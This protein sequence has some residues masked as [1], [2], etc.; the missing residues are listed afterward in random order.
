MHLLE[1]QKQY[2]NLVKIIKTLE[3]RLNGHDVKLARLEERQ[4]TAQ[5][6][7]EALGNRMTSVEQKSTEILSIVSEN[8]GRSSIMFK[9][10][11]FLLPLIASLELW[12]NL[13]K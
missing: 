10:L 5:E 1:E 6:A 12:S 11:M 4:E 8:R 3:D 9:L 13:S 7:I 2:S